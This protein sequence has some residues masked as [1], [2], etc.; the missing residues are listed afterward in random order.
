MADRIRVGVVG[1]SAERGWG[2]AVHLPALSARPDYEITA[3]AGTGMES[4]RA[5]A[6]VWG[7][8]HA[9]DDPH[10]LMACPDVDLVVIAVQ[11]TRRDGLVEAAIAAGKHVY[12]EWPLALSAASAERFR[13]SAEEAGVR[14]AVGL[15]SRHHPAIRRLRELLADGTIGDVLSASLTYS[16]AAPEAWPQRYSALF[17]RTKGVNH[18]AV[19]GG[20]SLDM[21]CSAVGGFTELSATL[22]TRITRVTVEETGE[23]IEVTSPDQIVLGGSLESGAAAS[24]HFMTGGPAGQ[25]FRIEVHGRTGRLVLRAS[26]DSLVGPEFTLH[27]HTGS[28]PPAVL[29]VPDRH[30]PILP[31]APV[32]VGNV[33][34]VYT[35]LA[36]AIRTGEPIEPD[37]S[38]AVRTH[39]LLDAVKKAA[40]TGERQRLA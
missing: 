19:V 30:R 16:L 26:D 8:R 37:F 12:C 36:R 4:A 32:A 31:G 7:A 39:R 3:V 34:Q 2:R 17:D 25:G 9:F 1:A 11:L 29:P 38:T 20:H 33:H 15:Q 24:A 28:E 22:A 40:E 23:P 14:H 10:A 27:H 35:D 21:F 13:A 5:A 18:L 6:R